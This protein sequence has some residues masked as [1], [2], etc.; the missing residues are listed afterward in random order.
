MNTNPTN[1]KTLISGARHTSDTCE[2]IVEVSN[3]CS[4]PQ[5]QE[6]SVKIK[7][8]AVEQI[9]KHGLTTAQSKLFF[10]LLKFDRDGS[11]IKNIPSL[12]EIAAA[13]GISINQV[14]KSLAKLEE[15]GFYKPETYPKG[16]WRGKRTSRS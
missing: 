8:E 4:D 9:I 12:E 7:D 2:N 10:Y 13:I 11:G 16:F 5:E 15:L 6:L 1:E 3:L 14:K